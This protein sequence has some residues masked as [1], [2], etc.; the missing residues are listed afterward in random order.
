[1]PTRRAAPPPLS[2]ELRRLLIEGPYVLG[3]A[4]PS[5]QEHDELRELWRLHGAA[6]EASLPRGKRAWFVERDWFVRQVRREP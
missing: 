3:R 5:K 6:I 2:P 4:L 1:M